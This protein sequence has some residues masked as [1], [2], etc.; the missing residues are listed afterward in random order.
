[1]QADSRNTAHKVLITFIKPA[2]HFLSLVQVSLSL[3]NRPYQNCLVCDRIVA[4][5]PRIFDNIEQDI[6]TYYLD[7]KTAEL[8]KLNENIENQITALQQHRKSLI[9]E[10]VTGKRRI[11]EEDMRVVQQ[12]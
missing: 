5:M 10:C 7:A 1:M 2:T 9:H 12:Y 8:K 11:T 3:W 6:L 4:S